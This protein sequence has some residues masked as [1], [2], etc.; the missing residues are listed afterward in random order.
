MID[1]NKEYKSTIDDLNKQ[2]QI[3]QLSEKRKQR[4]YENLKIQYNQLQIQTH[5]YKE[6]YNTIEKE[7]N[8]KY[9]III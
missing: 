6:L 3:S 1:E 7:Y 8:E 5:N 9:H 4:E 2:L